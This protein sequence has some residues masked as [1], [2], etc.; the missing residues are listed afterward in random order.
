MK[1]EFSHGQKLGILIFVLLLTVHTTYTVYGLKSTQHPISVGVFAD[2]DYAAYAL[3]DAAITDLPNTETVT[4]TNG[5][6][7]QDYSEW[8]AGKFVAGNEPDVVFILPSDL[9]LYRR[10]D[11]LVKLGILFPGDPD[12]D[13]TDCVLPCIEPQNNRT[14]FIGVSVRAHDKERAALLVKA[15]NQKAGNN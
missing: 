7:E 13:D 6:I 1:E 14:F 10:L 12:V 11:A 2:N 15:I 9:S 3:L 4:Y 5:I 8:L